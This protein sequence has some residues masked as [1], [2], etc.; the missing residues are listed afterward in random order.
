[1]KDLEDCGLI[2]MSKF[3]L[4]YFCEKFASLELHGFCDSSNVAYAAAVYVRIVTLVK[5]VVNLLSAKR[6]VSP[7]KD[8]TLK[9]LEFSVCLLLSKLVV[10][11]RKAVEVE[12]EIRSVMLWSDSEI[13]LYQIRGFRKEWKKSVENK[14]AKIR[15]LLGTEGWRFD[16]GEVNPA[17]LAKRHNFINDAMI[18]RL[19]NGPEVLLQSEDNW[20]SQKDIHGLPSRV[21]LEEAKK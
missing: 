19:K 1:M 20:P 4:S 9:R 11:V 7:L 12:V 8:V 2:C 21:T 17:D 13:A 3:V 16:P 6:K 18:K 5:V 10:S 14:V 15:L